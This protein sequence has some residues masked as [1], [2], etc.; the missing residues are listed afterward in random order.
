MSKLNSEFYI[1]QDSKNPKISRQNPMSTTQIPKIFGEI[2]SSG[3]VHDV[4]ILH[5]TTDFN[6]SNVV[7]NFCVNWFFICVIV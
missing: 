5:H 6:V 1:I 3:S 2:P 4:N 7:L